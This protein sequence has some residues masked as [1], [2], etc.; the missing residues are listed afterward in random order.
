MRERGRER[1]GGERE[2][3]LDVSEGVANFTGQLTN[4][5]NEDYGTPKI[6]LNQ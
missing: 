1:E 5:I 6:N 2:S 3:R 4:E